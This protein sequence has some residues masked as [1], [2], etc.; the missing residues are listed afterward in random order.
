M[1]SALFIALPVSAA[2]AS[3]QGS[4]GATSTGSVSINAS[5]PNRAQITG[6]SDVSF[7]NADPTVAASNAQSVCVWSNTSTKGYSITASG[8]GTSGAF[9]LASGT[10]PAVPYSV[11]WSQS[12]GQTSGTAVTK[13]VALTGQVSTATRPACSAAPATSASLVIGIAATDLQGMASN[14]SYTGTLTLVVAPE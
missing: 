9:T 6:L 5:V 11:Q 7:A 2:H 12:S 8:S 14:T 1:A 10:L 4:L 13:S 3:T